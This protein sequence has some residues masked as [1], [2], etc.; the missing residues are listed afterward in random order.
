M[1]DQCMQNQQQYFQSSMLSKKMS[2][3]T[4]G[5]MSIDSDLSNTYVGKT[6]TDTFEIKN[7]P[8]YECTLR[9]FA[10]IL[11][12]FNLFKPANNS[13]KIT[14]FGNEIFFFAKGLHETKTLKKITQNGT[15]RCGNYSSSFSL[16]QLN[17]IISPKNSQIAKNYDNVA[18]VF[19]RNGA[20]DITF[21]S[22]SPIGY[23]PVRIRLM[24]NCED[25]T[26]CQYF[27]L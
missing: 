17:E 6:S 14:C 10:D 16:T 11:N 22:I 12:I 2:E 5:E 21:F 20:I 15:N 25:E 27:S 26:D 9:E 13:I 23:N 4:L 7:E 19:K 18:M 1:T 8:Q 24:P 3:C